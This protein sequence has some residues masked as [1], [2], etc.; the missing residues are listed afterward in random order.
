MNHSSPEGRVEEI[1][2]RSQTAA[3]ACQSRR[4][5][6]QE[7]NAWNV[8]SSAQPQTGQVATTS[9][10]LSCLLHH[11]GKQL[12]AKRQAKFRT[13]GGAGLDQTAFHPSHEPSNLELVEAISVFCCS[14]AA[15]RYALFTVN[16]PDFSGAQAMESSPSLGDRRIF[17]SRRYQLGERIGAVS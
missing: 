13:L 10:F 1:S 5:L 6:I 8:S 14:S 4:A 7:Q 15:S 11:V 2:G 17:L 12:V 9:K 3:I 16:K